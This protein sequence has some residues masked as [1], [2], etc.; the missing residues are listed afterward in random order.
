MPSIIPDHF[1]QHVIEDARFSP[2]LKSIMDHTTTNPKPVSLDGFPLATRPQYIP[3]PIQRCPIIRSR[4]S[5]TYALWRFGYQ[6]LDQLPQFIR[7]LKVIYIFWF[8]N[9]I[10]HEGVSPVK[11]I[12]G[13]PI[14]HQMRPF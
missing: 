4:P 13:K 1:H 6:V 14:L 3:D 7:H 11:L 8:S 10:L 12:F 9:G 2:T 5:A